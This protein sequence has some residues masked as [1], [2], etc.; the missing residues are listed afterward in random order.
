MGLLYYTPYFFVRDKYGPVRGIS[1]VFGLLECH[2][3]I[4]SIYIF[5]WRSHKKSK[6]RWFKVEGFGDG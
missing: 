2:R 4:F 5:L 6:Y 3:R 1:K